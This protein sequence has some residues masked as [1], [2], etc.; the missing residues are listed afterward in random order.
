MTS[1]HRSSVEQ[2]SSGWLGTPFFVTEFNHLISTL[3]TSEWTLWQSLKVSFLS[4]DLEYW[5]CITEWVETFITIRASAAHSNSF[6]SSSEPICIRRVLP[7]PQSPTQSPQ[8]QPN[9]IWK[10]LIKDHRDLLDDFSS[11]Q[12]PDCAQQWKLTKLIAILSN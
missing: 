5:F 8:T 12:S 4:F 3:F 7:V 1:S 2:W 6:H 9:L 11:S 10:A